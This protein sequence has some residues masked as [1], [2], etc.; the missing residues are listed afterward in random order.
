MSKTTTGEPTEYTEQDESDLIGAVDDGWTEWEGGTPSKMTISAVVEWSGSRNVAHGGHRTVRLD[1]LELGPA[2]AALDDAHAA[3]RDV[4]R[5]RTSTAYTAQGWH[6]QINALTKHGRGSEMA[7]R[8]G[9]DVSPRTLRAWLGE[10]RAPS[11]ANREKIADAYAALGTSRLDDARDRQR[12][13]THEAT[14]AIDEAVRERY[15]ADV[16]FFGVRSVEFDD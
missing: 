9:L 8:A 5:A 1:G 3:S 10:D 14:R 2:K 16:R 12:R 7:D 4:S 6:A 11:K 15:G 13:A